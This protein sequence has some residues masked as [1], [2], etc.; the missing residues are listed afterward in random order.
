LGEL[1]KYT[2]PACALIAAQSYVSC[3]TG[4]SLSYIGGEEP[5]LRGGRARGKKVLTGTAVE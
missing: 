1:T 5:G 2:S 4:S 3:S